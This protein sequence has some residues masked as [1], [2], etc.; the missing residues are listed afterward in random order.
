MYRIDY[1]EELLIPVAHVRDKVK[2]KIEW[3]GQNAEAIP[4]RYLKGKLSGLCTIEFG[5]NFRIIYTVNHDL[6]IITI[7]RIG[8][9]N[10]VY[11]TRP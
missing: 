5:D 6:K 1:D 10:T 8:P 2:R 3:L 9:R 4:H 11:N 7:N